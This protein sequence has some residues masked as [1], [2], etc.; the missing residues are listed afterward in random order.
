MDIGQSKDAL[1]AKIKGA[2]VPLFRTPQY[3]LIWPQNTFKYSP[4]SL[5]RCD[6]F[7]EVRLE[8]LLFLA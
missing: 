2:L 3:Q 8:T 6:Y 7:L 4:V 5:K 1:E